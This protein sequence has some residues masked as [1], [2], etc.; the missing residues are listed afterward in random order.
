MIFPSL[1]PQVIKGGKIQ[2]LICYWVEMKREYSTQEWPEQRSRGW[3][4]GTLGTREEPS[5]VLRKTK[6]QRMQLWAGKKYPL[7]PDLIPEDM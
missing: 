4:T 7:G 3:P 6:E 5:L 2:T 1:N